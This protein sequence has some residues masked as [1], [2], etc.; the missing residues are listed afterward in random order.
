MRRLIAVVLAVA[1]GHAE[2]A[3]VQ[4]AV[5]PHLLTILIAL[6][7]TPVMLLRRRGDRRHRILGAVWL[8]AMLTTAI[9]SFNLRM[10][11][12]GQFSLIHLLSAWTI[13][14]VPVIWLSARKHRVQLHRRSVKGMTTGALLIAGFFTFPF[15]RLLGHW[16]FG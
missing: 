9:V 8:L 7:L 4:L 1:R 2:W 5:W 11:G 10:I 15:N 14:Q 3:R 16:L 12:H 6:V 13:I